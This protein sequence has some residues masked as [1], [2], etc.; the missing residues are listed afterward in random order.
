MLVLARRV[1]QRIQAGNVWIKVL[2]LRGGNAV[3][4]GVEAPREVP[5]WREELLPRPEPR[6]LLDAVPA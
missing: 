3:V 2:E 4:L 5:I 6:P 1:G